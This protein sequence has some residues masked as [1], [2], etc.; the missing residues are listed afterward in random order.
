LGN[1]DLGVSNKKKANK[2]EKGNKSSMFPEKSG[3]GEFKD[4][5]FC[6][7]DQTSNPTAK[8]QPTKFDYRAAEE[9][10][11]M[12]STVIKVNR[13]ARMK[14]WANQFRLMR[15]QD[16]VTKDEIKTTLKW[17]STRIGEPY[18]IE[19][20]SAGAFREKYT[21]LQ[22]AMRRPNGD[23][24]GNGSESDKAHNNRVQAVWGWIEKHHPRMNNPM[25]PEVEEAVAGLGLPEGSVTL[26]DL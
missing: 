6:E 18:M 22:S 16:G 14:D 15:E 2:I 7:E 12:V 10:K 21:G 17:Y 4:S 11:K 26:S 5:S 20:Y 19:A 3:N 23:E 13:R 9:L 25:D 24:N 1:T 8:K